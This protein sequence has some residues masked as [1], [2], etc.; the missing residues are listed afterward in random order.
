MNFGNLTRIFKSRF[1]DI[2]LLFLKIILFYLFIPYLWRVNFFLRDLFE[3]RK[4]FPRI[5]HGGK[6]DFLY[7]SNFTIY[8][9]STWKFNIYS[10]LILSVHFYLFFIHFRDKLLSLLLCNFYS[11]S[12]FYHTNFLIFVFKNW[13]SSNSG[14]CSRWSPEIWF[15]GEFYVFG[16]SRKTDLF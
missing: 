1:L 3:F 8:S 7:F 10:R 4:V 6:I 2:F 12:N 13:S 9:G 16:E 5:D 15:Y 14:Q 11:K